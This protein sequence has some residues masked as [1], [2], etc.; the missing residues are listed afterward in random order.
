MASRLA[1]VD[2]LRGVAVV[3]MIQTHLYDAWVHAGVKQTA[4]YGITRFL[5]GVPARLFL[6][7]VG[8]SLAIG[9]ESQIARGVA[10][11]GIVKKNFK[12]GLQVIG[13]AYLF[14]IQEYVL[15]GLGAN[16][17]DIFRVDILNCI[18]ATIIVCSVIA[19]PRGGRPQ[20]AAAVIGAALFLGLGPIIGPAH[21]PAFLPRPLTSYIGGQRPMSWFG[22]YPWAAWPCVGIVLGHLWARAAAAADPGRLA[23]AFLLPGAF[24]VLGWAAVVI[25]RRVDP[26]VIRY[27]SDLVQQMGPGSFF[28]RLGMILVIA[29]L[30]WAWVRFRHPAA[31]R[32]S[33]MEQFG[34]TSLFVYWIHVDLCYG[35][36]SKPLHGRLGMVSATVGLVAMTAAMLA[37]SLWR[38]TRFDPW[39][40]ARRHAVQ[41]APGPTTRSPA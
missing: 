41:P 22:L 30:G 39:W 9:W 18:G 32:F 12:R 25:I 19:A 31:A 3:L 16:W 15:G 38:T 33:V 1:S 11:G 7:L 24:G 37:L 10:R 35:L 40:K 17:A 13:M 20:I 21:F 4:A 23:R 36:V 2:W 28:Y 14:R 8:V 27:P 26:D 29:A 6:L 34:R 5:G